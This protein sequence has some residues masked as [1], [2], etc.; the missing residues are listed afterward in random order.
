MIPSECRKGHRR[1]ER[2]GHMHVPSA[3][4]SLEL[5]QSGGR[6]GVRCGWVTVASHVE[7]TGCVGGVGRGVGR[8]VRDR[9]QLLVPDP[10]G[11]AMY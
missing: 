10:T 1:A 8:G 4:I 11:C 5:D 9:P 6:G 2:L 3:T 7:P